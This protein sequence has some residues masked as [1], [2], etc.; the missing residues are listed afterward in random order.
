LGGKTPWEYL[1]ENHRE[2][3]LF[4]PEVSHMYG[5]PTTSWQVEMLWHLIPRRVL[6]TQTF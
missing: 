1:M 6:N 4:D 2:A 5:T 3:I